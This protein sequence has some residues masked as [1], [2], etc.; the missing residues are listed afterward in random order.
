MADFDPTDPVAPN[1]MNATLSL[2]LGM[3]SKYLLDTAIRIVFIR[4][5]SFI[6]GTF[7]PS[8]WGDFSDCISRTYYSFINVMT[9]ARDVLCSW[10][11]QPDKVPSDNPEGIWP[12]SGDMTGRFIECVYK[13]GSSP[14]HGLIAR[15]YWGDSTTTMWTSNDEGQNWAL[16][17][18]DPQGLAATFNPVIF[19]GDQY[20]RVSDYARLPKSPTTYIK[21]IDPIKSPPPGFVSIELGQEYRSALLSETYATGELAG[22][23]VATSYVNHAEIFCCPVYE[24]LDLAAG[25]GKCTFKVLRYYL[26]SRGNPQYTYEPY[27]SWGFLGGK[28]WRARFDS[29]SHDGEPYR[30]TAN[31][32][33][34]PAPF[35]VVDSKA[36]KYPNN[37]DG[38]PN[39]DGEPTLITLEGSWEA[40]TF[41]R[42]AYTRTDLDFPY[43]Y[44]YDP[45]TFSWDPGTHHATA[46]FTCGEEYVGGSGTAYLVF[47]TSI[48]PYYRAVQMSKSES[49][50]NGVWTIS[51][52]VTSPD[53]HGDISVTALLK[54]T[55]YSYPWGGVKITY[56]MFPFCYAREC[57]DEDRFWLILD[58]FVLR[59]KPKDGYEPRPDDGYPDWM[60]NFCTWG[61]GSAGGAIRQS[62]GNPGS[63]DHLDTWYAK[64]DIPLTPEDDGID[65]KVW[66]RAAM[67]AEE[68]SLP[69]PSNFGNIEGYGDA[70]TSRTWLYQL[71]DLIKGWYSLYLNQGYSDKHSYQMKIDIADTAGGHIGTLTELYAIDTDVPDLKPLTSVVRYGKNKAIGVAS[72]G[73]GDSE[74]K[75]KFTT[76][77]GDSWTTSGPTQNSTGTYTETIPLE[78]G[79]QMVTIEAKQDVIPGGGESGSDLYYTKLEV[80]YADLYSNGFTRGTVFASGAV[81]G[82]NRSHIRMAD[83]NTVAFLVPNAF[84]NGLDG[85]LDVPNPNSELEVTGELELDNVNN[86]PPLKIY[87][88]QLFEQFPDLENAQ[89]TQVVSIEYIPPELRDE[90]D[91]N[92]PLPTWTYSSC[93]WEVNTIELDPTNPLPFQSTAFYKSDKCKVKIKF[94]YVVGLRYDIYLARFKQSGV[95]PPTIVHVGYM[96]ESARRNTLT[97]MWFASSEASRTLPLAGNTWK[98]G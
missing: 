9:T 51:A 44:G 69:P 97:P 95:G 81:D 90:V 80:G 31:K 76:D 98:E 78:N 25:T 67:G 4:R 13:D 41:T 7:M 86:L 11:L 58:G 34:H 84:G 12:C 20:T 66:C 1:T 40:S 52:E 94:K 26:W 42:E 38:S 88:E 19:A 46:T 6:E 74:Q 47:N 93:E 83:K 28:M 53:Q 8:T 91:P 45:T 70:L 71:A 55:R 72:A 54:A 49:F 60:A 5:P 79:K 15:Q 18:D 22:T 39:F 48:A 65:S 77:G 57:Y 89:L 29:W 16:A 21:D 27:R 64:A 24:E 35:A 10:I 3:W 43:D 85:K 2:K 73:P 56:S 96:D 17:M 59:G 36:W 62:Y 75:L 63:H 50:N 30:Y 33:T 82:F 68:T 61:V 23:C 32:D 92:T 14:A 87:K 37:G